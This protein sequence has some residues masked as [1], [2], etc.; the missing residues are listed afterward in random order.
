MTFTGL[1]LS[2]LRRA[3]R[4]N[5][6]LF[7]LVSFF[8]DISSEMVYPLLP[9]F[10]TGLV[11]PAVAAIY[12]GLMDGL[13]ESVSSLLKIYSGRL[14]DRLGRRKPLALTGYAVSSLARPLA[15]L[16][17]AGWHVIALRVMDRVGKGIRTSPRDALLSESADRDVRGLAFSF[18]RLLDHAGAVCGPVIAAVFL[19][20]VLGRGLIWGQGTSAVSAE[21]MRAMRWLFAAALVPGL[22]ATVILWRWV[23]ES[24]QKKN[25][26]DAGGEQKTLQTP[27]LPP[28]FFVF[29]GAVTLFTLG[30]STDLF[31]IFYAQT[32]F[33]LGLGWV[34]ALWV[35]LHISKIIFSLPGGRFSDR[36]GRR[37]AIMLGWMIYIVIY[38]AMPF[39][40]EFWVTCVLLFSYGAYYGM[41]EGAERA[42]VADF[43]SAPQ[44]GKAYGLYHGAVGLAALPASLLFGVFWAKLGPKAAFLIGASAAA[45]A[46]LLLAYNAPEKIKEVP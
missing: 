3:L 13:A 37:S 4:G 45:A 38:A 19:Y 29:L 28:K 15:A 42:M 7:G 9:M 40:S 2:D 8:N 10:F 27:S 17:T 5:V 26:H 14:S 25:P 34:I 16:A 35:M 23:R 43:V 44:R 12:I 39:V 21:E 6:F 18:H 24:P 32:H 30:N 31:L 20:F 1:P 11:S 46:L 41:T 36:V 22:A 33:G